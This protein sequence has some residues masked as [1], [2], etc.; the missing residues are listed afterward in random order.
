MESGVSRC[1]SLFFPTL[2]YPPV[3]PA[4]R[5]LFFKYIINTILCFFVHL[6][7]FIVDQNSLSGTPIMWIANEKISSTTYSVTSIE[8]I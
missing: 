7:I 6:S 1:I 2:Q 4:E 5:I 8:S 3:V